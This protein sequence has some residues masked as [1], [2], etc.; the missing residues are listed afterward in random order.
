M[1]PQDS[2]GTGRR[3]C[4]LFL[5]L[6][7]FFSASLLLSCGRGDAER[8]GETLPEEQ[9]LIVYTSHK[10]EV[11]RPLIL[12]FEAKTGIFVELHAGGSTEML[13]RLEEDSGYSECDIMFGGGVELL[14]ADKEFLEP[15]RSSYADQIAGRFLSSDDSWT[16]FTELPLVFIYNNKLLSE[17]EAPKSWRE[18]LTE[19]WRGRIA[20]ADPERSGTSYTILQTIL[21]LCPG[22][23]DEALEDFARALSGESAGGSG[24]V[25]SEVESGEK[26][27]GITLEESAWKEIARGEDLS[28][29][30]PEEGSSAVPDGVAVAK[31]APHPENARRFVDFCVSDEVQRYAVDELYRRPVRT[32][33]PGPGGEDF[34]V[35]PLSIEKMGREKNALLERWAELSKG[36]GA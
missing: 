5:V 13:K 7:L 36:G 34:P 15:Y 18:L 19:R 8:R 33:I 24:E 2:E 11:Y 25:L 31:N 26:L 30:Y 27:M 22:R 35:L 12:E 3:L 29:V 14:E 10:E 20:F 23:E 4:L 28:L 21:S 6:S 1:R 32:D 17:E 9:K 16:A